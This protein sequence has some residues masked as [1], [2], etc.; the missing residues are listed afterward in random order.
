MADDHRPD[1]FGL[2]PFRPRSASP[3]SDEPRAT[4]LAL[5]A[6]RPPVPAVV[7]LF[8]GRPERIRSGVANGAVLRLAG[9]W[10]TTG[11]WWSPEERF[12]YD[13]FDILTE[14]GTV[15][16]LRFDHIRRA[17]HIDAVYD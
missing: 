13:S 7:H 4:A 17:W 1:R 10:R 16:R 12:A 6:L 15:A 2:R 9:P 5:R 8:R 3:E 14:D 11:G